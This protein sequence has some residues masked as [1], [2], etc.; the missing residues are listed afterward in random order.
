MNDSFTFGSVCSGIEAAQLAFNPLNFKQIWSSEIAT[1]PSKVLEHHYPYV[2]NIGDMNSITEYIIQQKIDSPDIFCGGTPCQAFSLA[3][4]K[5]GLTDERGLLTMKFIEIAD[6]ID[7]VRTS[8][9]KKP[10][11]IL[12]ENVEG[13]LNDK[14]N[15]FGNFIA[16]LAGFDQEIKVKKWSKSGILY[17]KSRNVAWRVLDA[18][19]FGLPQQRK[20]LYVIAGGKDIKPEKI[21]FELNSINVLRSIKFKKSTLKTI[22][23][24]F[25]FKETDPVIAKL[26]YK[27]N[28][29]KFQ[30]FREYTDCLYSAYGTKWNGNAAAYNGSLYVAQ[31][32]KI[33]RLTPLECERLMGIPDNYTLIEGNS[34]TNRYQAI[35]NSWAVPVVNWIGKRIKEYDSSKND[36]KISSNLKKTQNNINSDLYLLDDVTKINHNLYLNTSSSSNEPTIGNIFDIIQSE[37]I[38][39]K[40]FLSS[41]ACYGILRRKY[42]RNMK[43]NN[44]LEYLMA[45]SCDFEL[46]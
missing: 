7:K 36:I 29:N 16:G 44:E 45:L 38:P 21:L 23:T 41:K 28:N 18:K 32:D 2:P 3:G 46:V 34:D 11:I 12:W 35:G 40:L 37:D 20:R 24:L 26:I 42:E 9:K 4:W 30:F 1:F 13:V 27:K 5:N 8:L 33:R 19:Y 25:D 22:P 39:D 43:M 6:A 10:S 17:G 14:T 31:N 15:A